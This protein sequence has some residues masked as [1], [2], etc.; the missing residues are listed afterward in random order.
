MSTFGF[1]VLRGQVILFLLMELII[2]LVMIK[3]IISNLKYK[4]AYILFNVMITTYIINIFTCH[5]TLMDYLNH[6]INK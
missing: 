5:I 6:L 2:S 4:D 1:T 3:K